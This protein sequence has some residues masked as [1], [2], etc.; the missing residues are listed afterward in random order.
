MA[1]QRL[2]KRQIREDP[3]VTLAGNVR[4]WASINATRILMVAA[5]TVII[6]GLG[7]GWR[8]AQRSGDREA[9][10]QLAM[11]Q[12]QLWGNNPT[13]AI[14]LADDIIARWPGSRSA[15]LSDLV[16]GDALLRAGRAREALDA[17][18]SFLGQKSDTTLRVTAF[19]GE[20]VA[21]ED[22]GQFAAAAQSYETLARNHDQGP[23]I[24]LDLIAAA[25]CHKQ[26]GDT[27]TALSLYEEVLRDHPNIQERTLVELQ[28]RELGGPPPRS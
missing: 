8:N 6:I 13:E 22:T 24:A 18:R 23:L 20:A 11:A 7:I 26:D 12:F 28:I 15:R 4:R 10:T 3:L 2:T 1:R 27:A 19:R 16:R 9:A 17:Y 25:R 5:A 14:E 21:L